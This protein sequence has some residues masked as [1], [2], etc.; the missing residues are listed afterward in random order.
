MPTN[1]PVKWRS[2]L[3]SIC[4]VVCLTYK[5]RAEEFCQEW[6]NW[7]DA[8]LTVQSEALLGDLSDSRR[9][10]SPKKEV[11]SDLDDAEVEEVINR[12]MH[13][14]ARDYCLK[15]HAVGPCSSSNCQF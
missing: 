6:K 13:R 14:S 5:A 11:E 8:P 1:M 3:A 4:L 12:G 10:G 2:F 9:K 15:N 7:D